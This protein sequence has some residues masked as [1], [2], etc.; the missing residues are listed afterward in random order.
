MTRHRQ[1]HLWIADQDYLMLRDLAHERNETLS[2]VI[3][4]LIR[5]HHRGPKLGKDDPP[6]PMDPPCQPPAWPGI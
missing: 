4:S 1:L 2:A 3:R 5:L 6:P